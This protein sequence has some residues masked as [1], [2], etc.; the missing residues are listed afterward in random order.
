MTASRSHAVAGSKRSTRASSPS[1]FP[2]SQ[3][4]PDSTSPE[5]ASRQRQAVKIAGAFVVS[6]SRASA[7]IVVYTQHIAR[8][9]G[10]VTLP[11]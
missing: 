7:S 10:Q 1:Q 5:R 4:T 11:A 9:R 2:S 3:A 6:S 8:P